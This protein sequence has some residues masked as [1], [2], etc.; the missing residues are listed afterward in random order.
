MDVAGNQLGQRPHP[1]PADWI[2][3]Q[4]RRLRMHFVEIFDDRQRLREHLAG[5]EGQRRHAHLRIDR[6][7]LRLLVET[8]LLLQMDRNHLAA[9]AFQI[10]RDANSISRG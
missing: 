10:E 9:Q 8:A 3:R 1:R 5:V 6:A 2:G 4:Q 7:V